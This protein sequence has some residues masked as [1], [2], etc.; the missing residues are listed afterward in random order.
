MIFKT[1]APP[2]FYLGPSLVIQYLVSL[3]PYENLSFE[4]ISRK[5]ATLLALTTAQRLQILAVIQL[6]QISILDTGD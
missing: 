4:L 1:L 2:L 3:Y 6:P 5:L